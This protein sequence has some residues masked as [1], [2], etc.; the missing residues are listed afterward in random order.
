MKLKL[1]EV[2]FYVA[3]HVEAPLMN[4]IALRILRKLE[5]RR[6]HKLPTPYD[7]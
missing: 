3:Y 2:L 4:K 5:L 7:V 6:S 1:A